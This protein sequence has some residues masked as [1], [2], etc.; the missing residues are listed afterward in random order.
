MT[1]TMKSEPGRP[2]LFAE[3]SGTAPLSMAISCAVGG[4]TAGRRP[5]PAG[6]GAASALL[7][8][9]AVA[10]ATATPAR[11]LR[12]STLVCDAFIECLPKCAL[13]HDRER[14][15]ADVLPSAVGC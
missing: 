14:A 1:S 8:D 12:R 5:P 11:N 2:W 13:I 7:M 10:P 4:R 15:E 9:A 6:V 3:D